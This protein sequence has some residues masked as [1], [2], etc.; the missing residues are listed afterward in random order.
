M[1]RLLDKVAIVTGAAGGMGAAEAKLFAKEGAKVLATDS[2]EEKL[3]SWVVAARAEGLEI[4]YMKHNVTSESDWKKVAN[5]AME[6]YGK[7]DILVNNAGIYPG[8]VSCEDTP[9]ELW[10]NVLAIN[11]TGPFIGCK[12]CIPFLRLSGGASIINVASIAG[13]V[14]G[15]G[16][17]Y[18]ASKGGL[19]LFSKDL[20]VLLAKDKIRVNTICPGGVLTPMTEEL[21]KASGMEEMIHQMS[22]QGRMAD[23]IEIANGALF[24][25]SDE[26]SFMTGSDLVMDGGSV[27]R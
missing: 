3:K 16:A 4:Q 21:M 25:A 27:A 1:K 19:V 22:P 18:T 12:T 13:L 26:S 2:N 15:N 10:G 5:K 24:L 17:A 14:G 23:P 20:A 6:L 8:Y 7:L 9:I 11:L